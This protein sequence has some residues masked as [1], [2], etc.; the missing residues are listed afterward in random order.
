MTQKPPEHKERSRLAAYVQTIQNLPQMAKMN[1]IKT[2]FLGIPKIKRTAKIMQALASKKLLKEEI[3]TTL[4]NARYNLTGTQKLDIHKV[5]DRAK[6]YSMYDSFIAITDI[7]VT[8]FFNWLEGNEFE[9][10]SE[11]NPAPPPKKQRRK[12]PQQTEASGWQAR[13]RG[14]F[15][16]GKKD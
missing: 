2:A 3:I 10:K 16:Q 4:I 5:P 6:A 8:D 15:S 7:A 1:E 14:W 12:K 13:I 9:T 11:Y